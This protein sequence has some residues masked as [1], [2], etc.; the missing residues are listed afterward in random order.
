MERA[1]IEK[2]SKAL[3]DGTRLRIFEAISSREGMICGDLVKLRGV[4]PATISHHLKILVDAGLVECRRE[5]Q[6][7]HSRAVPTTIQEYARALAR[8]SGRKNWKR[9]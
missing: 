7:V 6:C 5:G 3:A 1:R 2:I 9:A 4:T 8:I